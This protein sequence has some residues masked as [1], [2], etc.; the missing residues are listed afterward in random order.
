MAVEIDPFRQSVTCC[1]CMT[2]GSRGTVRQNGVSH[3]SVYEAEVCRW[4]PLCRKNYIHWH[5]LMLAEHLCTV[6]QWVVRFSSGNS[7]ME[8]KPCS[9]WPCVAV[10]KWRVILA[11]L[12]ESADY[13]QGTV[14][15][16]AHQLQGIR[17]DIGTVGISQSLHQVGSTNTLTGTEGYT[18][19]ILGWRWISWIASSQV[20]K[21][22]IATVSWNQKSSP[23]SGNMWIPLWSKC[24]RYSHQWV[25]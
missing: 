17:D 12:C 21:C 19:P 24:S 5:S 16:A 9:R 7:D 8:E 11:H 25:K 1:C 4:I 6:R 10:M 3:G 22:G 20:M 13:N 18:E 2:D 15:R 23:W 14:Y